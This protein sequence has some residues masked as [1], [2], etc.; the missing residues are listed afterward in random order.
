MNKPYTCHNCG[1]EFDALPNNDFPE[2]LLLD[3][4]KVKCPGCYSNGYTD[5]DQMIYTIDLETMEV[6]S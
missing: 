6:V 3:K 5:K 4:V 1:T 2:W